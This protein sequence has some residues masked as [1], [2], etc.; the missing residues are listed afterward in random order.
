M[1]QKIL[2]CQDL[3]GVEGNR[4]IELKNVSKTYK[5]GDV[6]VNALKNVSLKIEQ[7]EFLAIIGASGA[8]KSTLLHILGFLDKPDSGSYKFLNEEITKYTENETALLRNILVGFVFQQ[9]YLL[10]RT[11]VLENVELP[12]I[13]AGK[14]NLKEK[15][16][17]K[18]Q[19]VKLAKRE[20]HKPNE[21]SGG[22]QQR[23]AIARA[24]VNDPLLILAD[25]PT[26]NLDSK[27]EREIIAILE[28]LN[29][30]GKTIVLVTHNN[31][32]AEHAKR[33][34]RMHDGE[35]VSDSVVNLKSSKTV[36][37]ISS[38]SSIIKSRLSKG[39][40]LLFIDH[41][42]QA[43]RAI[44]SHPMRSILS[45]L[46]VL[47]GVAAV[48]AMLALGQGAKESISKNLA[49]LGSNLL[50]IMPGAPRVGGVSLETGVVTRFTLQDEEY[51]SEIEHIKRTSSTVSGR[52]QVVY[53]SKNWNT[54]IL[55]AGI[56]YAEMHASVPVYG[57]FFNENE[58]KLRERVVVLG[59]TVA[60]QL[61]GEDNPIGEIIKIK[62]IYFQ[63]IGVL[64]RR[65]A[66]GFR[67][68]DDIVIVP[69]TTAMYRLL[70]KEYVDTIEVEVDSPNNISKV[71]DAIK[72]KIIKKHGLTKDKENS[73]NI[74]DMTQIQDTLKST[75]QT[76][77]MLLGSIA[78]I[79]MLVG[80]IG[81]MNIMLV[82]VSERTKEIG[83]RKA[84][85]A[86]GRDIMLQFLI[87]SVTMSLI[88]GIIGIVVGIGIGI[89]FSVILHW[90]T[91]VSV[92]SIVLVT[93]FSIGVG[94]CFGLLPAQKAAKLHPI[95]ALRYE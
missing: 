55:G 15:A 88:G 73:F 82:S 31:E 85:G 64:P 93:A 25:E 49:S 38:D 63:V 54:Q 59:T 39:K 79:S 57:R 58:I 42:K 19:E 53:G 7:G 45:M 40:S 68:Q 83:L 78:A 81:I 17:E 13:Y 91:V 37:T 61:F 72:E 80:G 32:V 6:Y 44:I 66:T 87:E 27:T 50:I 67:D 71:Q 20:F 92:F 89:L 4:M 18:I 77:T 3:A 10:P 23:V 26:G 48:I 30:K 35:I 16:K 22:E 65:G 2:L 70:G 28:D 43:F 29:R 33:I 34:I 51:I 47:I 60:S 75:T 84:I 8:G 46:G 36:T 5:M 12:L 14:S 52:G 24:L 76:M 94:I 95:E 11:T 9:F 56:N 21:L 69:V 86:T 1:L 90:T 62:R 74:R 41:I